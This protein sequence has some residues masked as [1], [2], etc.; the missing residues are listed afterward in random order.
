MGTSVAV[1]ETAEKMG[2]DTGI[3]AVHPLDAT[4][5]LP[6]FVANFVLMEYG[7]G[8]I[9]GCPGHDQRDID[10]A[11]KYGRPV[12]PVVAPR[13][14]AARAAAIAAIETGTAY[15]GDGV[16][17]NSRFL[18]GM[19]TG[20]AFETVANR[21]S[22]MQLAGHPVGERKTNYRL[23]DWGISRQRY[24]GCPIPVIHCEDCGVVPVPE[25]E[26][27]VKL[28]EDVTFDLPGNPLDR[29]DGWRLVP[30]PRCQKLARRETDTMDTFVDSSWYFARFTDPW[31]EAAPTDRTA[32]DSWLPVNQYIGGIEHAILH[33]LYS[34][35]FVRAMKRTGHSGL[36]E[37]FEGL[38]TQGMVLHETYKS[39]D[40]GWVSPVDVEISGSGDARTAKR[41]SDGSTITIGPIE[42]MSK[43]ALN[44]VDPDDIID[45]FGAD[46]A[47]WFMLSDSPPEREFN[48]TDDGVHGAGRFVQRLWRL[49]TEIAD[50]ASHAAGSNHFASESMT[51]RRAAHRA[52]AGI[53][54]DIERLRFNKAVA[55][56][57]ELA[58]AVQAA[59]LVPVETP[60]INAALHEAGLILAQCL[61]PMMPHL[62]EECW[63]ALGQTGLV[64][65]TAWPSADPALLI[66]DELVLPVQVNGKK[67]ADVT[68]SRTASE[69]EI[70]E[71]VLGLELVIKALEGRP[72]KKLII[73]PQR[74][75][76]V[77]G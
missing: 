23:R 60:G 37:P 34:R 6:V 25:Q 64:S 27:P 31:N 61:G 40:G 54:E 12:I 67:R 42:K 63:A 70:R 51:L 58:N 56:T 36:S 5:L 55:Q 75:I 71:A 28:P 39:A 26:L 4:I 77:V 19:S 44:T 29:H 18:D 72:V 33:L 48:W 32:V 3:K 13:D 66:D 15:D 46:T 47:R 22:G 30:C 73:V 69:A 7:T 59:L 45:S 1:L 35:F 57:Y 11:R 21:L 53:Q 8:A 43:S 52:L 65:S 41:R 2:F 14:E 49:V 17:I 76:N 38:F 68:V 24:W 50:R 20:E 74:I 16:M 9:F 10:F 62:A